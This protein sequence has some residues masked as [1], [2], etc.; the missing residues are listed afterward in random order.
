MTRE[1]PEQKKVEKSSDEIA[2]EI[3]FIN[4]QTLR[5]GRSVIRSSDAGATQQPCPKRYNA[6]WQEVSSCQIEY[7]RGGCRDIVN[8][9]AE[10]E[11]L[12]KRGAKNN[13]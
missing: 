13:Q 3:G 6:Y 8:T 7:G 4:E 1:R 5:R 10:V 11:T 12:Q 2:R 9:P